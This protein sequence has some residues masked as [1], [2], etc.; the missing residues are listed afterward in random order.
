[1]VECWK[2]VPGWE[3]Y[4]VSSL[5]RVRSLDRVVAYVNGRKQLYKG[6]VLSGWEERGYLYV[7]LCKGKSRRQCFPV[8]VLVC[9]AFHGPRPVGGVCRHLNDKPCDNRASNLKWGTPQENSEDAFR[10]GRRLARFS[11]EVL[12]EIRISDEVQHV[13]AERL[14][15]SQALVSQ[16]RSGKKYKQFNKE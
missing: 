4:E 7:E 11:R 14:G 6:R 13:L 1:M 9:T 2:G 16:I 15:V 8:S 5:G 3:Y 12:R 10:N